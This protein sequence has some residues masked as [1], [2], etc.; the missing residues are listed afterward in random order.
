MKPENKTWYIKGI[1]NGWP[2]AVGYFAVS[3]AL[4]IAA[5]NVGF[6]AL[7]ATV[8]SALFNAS[9]GEYA[10]IM[11]AGTG[12]SVL[13]AVIMEAVANAR[14]LLMSFSLS[15]KLDP[16]LSTGHRLLLS[17]YITD[18]FFALS[19]AV[20]GYLNP[21]YTY[22]MI[23][24]AA[25]AWAIG[26]GLGVIVGNVLPARVVSALSVSLF[27]MFIAII[28][29]PARRNKVLA[30]FVFAAMAL[31]G[32][33]AFAPVLKEI[34][35]GT[36]TIVLTVILSLVAALLFPVEEEGKKEAADA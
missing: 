15:Q 11:M 8:M 6:T 31:S 19:V 25:P 7:Q 10:A 2:I 24:L 35:T 22:G 36:R 21:F 3:F 33:C 23:S 29:P 12:A 9:A 26:T 17:N 30:G 16:S 5:R 4:G 27:G 13:E 32:I 34:S 28:I 1:R 18:E 14:Y 20:P